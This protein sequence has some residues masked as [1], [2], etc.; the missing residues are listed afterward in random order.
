MLDLVGAGIAML[1]FGGARRKDEVHTTSSARRSIG[2]FFG[3]IFEGLATVGFFTSA[4]IV[5]AY[6]KFLLGGALTFFGV[7]MFLR[8]KRGRVSKR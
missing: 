2:E 3:L 1:G 7:L 8:F 4:A 5:S 6:G